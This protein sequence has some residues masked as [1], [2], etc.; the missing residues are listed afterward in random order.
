MSSLNSTVIVTLKRCFYS[1]AVLSPGA[2]EVSQVQSSVRWAAL[3]LCDELG[4]AAH[5]T[6]QVQDFSRGSEG[7]VLPSSTSITLLLLDGWNH[8]ISTLCRQSQSQVRGA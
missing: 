7:R 3:G 5:L 8:Q 4:H 6:F 1:Q 2:T